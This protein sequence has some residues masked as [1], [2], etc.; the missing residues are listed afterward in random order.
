MYLRLLLLFIPIHAFA[1]EVKL[2]DFSVYLHLEK[3][4]ILSQDVTTTGEF[5]TQNFHPFGVGIPENELFHDFLIQVKLTSDSEVY[6]P[7]NVATV[8]VMSEAEKSI[9][10]E[11]VISNVY[12]G[13]EKGINKAVWISGQG[14]QS[15][16]VTVST[17]S[18]SITKRLPF[19]CG[20]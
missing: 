14:C 20:E 6:Q 10:K 17:Q 5:F 9:I 11:E 18:K 8:E 7:G 15:L 4:G 1:G 16:L 13:P 12:I 2:D 19:H 3:S